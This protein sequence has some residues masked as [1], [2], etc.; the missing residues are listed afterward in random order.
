MSIETQ[1]NGSLCQEGGSRETRPN[2]RAPFSTKARYD[3]GTAYGSADYWHLYRIARILKIG[4]GDVFY[5]LG[6]GK[7][8]M[9]C[10]IARLRLK[11]CVGVELFEPLCDIARR[12]AARLR[13]KKT[14]VEILRE[15]ASQADLSDGTIYYMANPF[16]PETLRDVLNNIERSLEKN[17]RTVTIVYHNALHEAVFEGRP[18]WS[19]YR[20]FYNLNGARISFW[21]RAV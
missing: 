7:G 14:P 1:P 9:I 6:S 21:R 20:S 19:R 3:D 12:N 11:K 13:G 8:R 15:D 4:P 17:P 5:D 2:F 16:G 18:G 10:V